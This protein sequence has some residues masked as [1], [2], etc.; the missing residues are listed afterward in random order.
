MQ[1]IEVI[2]DLFWTETITIFEFYFR[3]S[4]LGYDQ[5]FFLNNLTILKGN[6]GS[7]CNKVQIQKKSPEMNNL[8]ICTQ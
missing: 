3:L 4:F 1:I 6:A 2:S 8:D 5:M 7:F